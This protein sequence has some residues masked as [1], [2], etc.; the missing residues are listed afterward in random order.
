[1]TEITETETVPKERDN[2]RELFFSLLEDCLSHNTFVKMVL[3]KYHGAEPGLERLF[4][5]RLTLKE[6]ECLSFLYRYQSKDITK[7]LPIPAGIATLRDLFATSFNNLHLQTVSEDI[8]LSINKKGKCTLQQGKASGRS[9]PLQEHDREK[10]RFLELTSPFLRE[11][12]VTNQQH[13][14]LPSMARKWK[15]INKFIEVLDHAIVAAKLKEK[16]RLRVVD[17]GSGKGYLTFAMEEYLRA[18]LG[19]KPSVTGVELR[20]DLVNLCSKAARK[21]KL[22]DLSFAQGDI[23]SFPPESIDIIIA[24]HACDMATDYAIHL[25]VRSGASIIMCAP[26]CHKQIR[27]QMTSPPLLKPML[28]HG[29]HLGQEA[30]M[31]TDSLRALLLEAS[32]YETQIFE[33]VSLEHTS[34]NKMILGVKTGDVSKQAERLEQ[35]REIKAFYGIREHCLESLLMAEGLGQGG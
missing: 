20:E 8:Q 6:G 11:L 29:I 21:L 17:F 32:G 31:V 27:P 16:K 12:G 28:K 35:I 13:Q 1:M 7:N 5:R 23:R 25:G 10:E 15:Q 24:L 14:L 26:C 19:L 4:V 30:E 22:D 3:G 18:G 33:F 9:V 34:K 2:Q